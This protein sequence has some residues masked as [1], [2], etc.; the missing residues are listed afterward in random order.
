MGLLRPGSRYSRRFVRSG[1]PQLGAPEPKVADP[2]CSATQG[3][4]S[5]ADLFAGRGRARRQRPAGTD[6]RARRPGAGG[7]HD[8]G[9]SKPCNRLAGALVAALAG[10]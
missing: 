9:Q 10:R 7:L 6:Y 4:D 8:S 5:E 1:R 2:G 3:G